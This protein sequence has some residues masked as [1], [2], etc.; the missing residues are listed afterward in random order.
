MHFLESSCPPDYTMLSQNVCYRLSGVARSRS[1]TEQDCSSISGGHLA[2][3]DETS[4]TFEDLVEL[5]MIA[6]DDVTELPTDYVWVKQ[7]EGDWDALYI[8]RCVR[9]SEIERNYGAKRIMEIMR[10][11]MMVFTR[12]YLSFIPIYSPKLYS[13]DDNHLKMKSFRSYQEK[14]VY[15]IPDKISS[16]HTRTHAHSSDLIFLQP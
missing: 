1:E 16:T 7:R 8:L 12:L 13:I 5:A 6:R 11:T 3:I 14:P 15:T 10:H 9:K 2:T 4:E